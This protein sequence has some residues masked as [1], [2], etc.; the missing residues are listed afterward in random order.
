[1]LCALIGDDLA[2]IRVSAGTAQVLGLKRL[3]CAVLPTTAYF[4]VGEKC[5]RDCA[6]CSR[7]RSSKSNQNLLAR[8]T[9][10]FFSAEKAIENL[11]EAYAAGRLGRTCLQVVHSPEAWQKAARILEKIRRACT[12]PVSI[13]CTANKLD[14]IK[15]W[16]DSGAQRFGLALDAATEK[17]FNAVKGRHWRQTLTLLYTAADKWPGRI[18]THLIV[19]LGESDREI[20]G[21]L[22]EMVD[23]GIR[24][25]L[26]AFTPVKGTRMENVEPPALSRYRCIQT[27]Y[28]LIKRCGM[29]TRDFC[30]DEKGN[31]VD[32]GLAEKELQAILAGGGAFRTTGC[33]K[34]NRPFYNEHPGGDI[35]NYPYPPGKQ[36]VDAAL[37]LL[38]YAVR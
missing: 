2:V 14:D 1:M 26:F 38:R 36:E 10:P 25:G 33:D 31:L 32:F 23:L 13:S 8:I 21:R 15:C 6:F 3:K 20:I 12:I 27:A 22:Q 24:V 4:L 37:K 5:L 18:T 30:F 35:Y 11:S 29:N 7:S 19:G 17:I 9:W 34:C 28:Y 16:F